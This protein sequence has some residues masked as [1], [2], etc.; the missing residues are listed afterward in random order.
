MLFTAL[1]TSRNYSG[2][3]R[4]AGIEL[5]FTG[6][7]IA[8]TTHLLQKHLGGDA[9]AV[10]THKKILQN[11]KVGDIRIEL[12]MRLM[13]Q[14]VEKNLVP[15]SYL[16]RAAE[17]AIAPVVR[18]LAP[19]E[20]V[21][22]PLTLEQLHHF[23][24]VIPALRQAGAKGTG[25][26]ATHA[27]GLHINVEAPSLNASHLLAYIQAFI[28]L[29]DWLESQLETDIT[30][31]I[32]SFASSYPEEYAR[33]VLAPNYAPDIRQLIEDYIA[34]NPTRDRALDM[35]AIFAYF[36]PELVRHKS[37]DPLVHPYPSFHFRMPNCRIDEP[38]WDIAAEWK[39]WVY[40]EELA[41]DNRKRRQMA[42]HYLLDQE[43]LLSPVHNRWSE[44]TEQWLGIA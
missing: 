32:A 40:V 23:N 14:L 43:R 41:E 19:L 6:L 24:N 26:S 11:S 28:L 16:E 42:V 35:L 44:E 10:N 4:R 27:F 39:Y 3:V 17:A 34:Y 37:R 15:H 8:Q 30:R 7:N 21:T 38:G 31:R 33:H 1:P 5:E 12:D 25:A 2:T 36:E 20:I 9:V 22:A 29:Y 18:N 13:Q